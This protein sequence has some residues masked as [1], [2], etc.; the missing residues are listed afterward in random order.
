MKK[1]IL[2]IAIIVIIV[3]LTAPN[4]HIINT[5]SGN[6]S[7]ITNKLQ[8]TDTS[9]KSKNNIISNSSQFY[10][11]LRKHLLKRENNFSITYY[12]SYN[13]IENDGNELLKQIRNL[14]YKD[15]S[16][17]GEFLVE[18]I[19]RIGFNCTHN[20]TRC[21]YTFN[22]NYSETA[23]QV[24]KLNKKI[25][26][27]LKKLKIEKYSK[28]K[29]TKLIHDY[30]VNTVSYDQTLSDYTAYGALVDKKHSTVCQGYTQLMY[31]MLTEAGINAHYI[32]GK[33]TNSTGVTQEH[34][35]N[36]VKLKGK[37]YYIDATWDDPIS[38]EPI[39]R[40]DYFL[41]GSNTL[42]KDHQTDLEYD[43]YNVSFIDFK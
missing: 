23:E 42:N 2:G 39:L 36:I 20:S 41:V 33:A 40:Y 15:T 7:G 1:N 35:W 10:R 37:W 8:L 27:V 4:R 38:T 13:S 34:A 16:D 24:K 31:K 43:R 30:V 17:D 3:L 12:G 29:R 9:D 21:V 11:E 18:D 28:Y 22:V 26:K 19:T 14:D 5:I 32:S 25:K 6:F